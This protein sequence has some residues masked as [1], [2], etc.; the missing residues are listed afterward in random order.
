MIEK[1]DIFASNGWAMRQSCYDAEGKLL[2]YY[3]F[4]YNLKG[5]KD[6][7]TRCDANGSEIE[8][9]ELDYDEEGRELVS[10]GTQDDDGMIRMIKY[11]FEYDNNTTRTIH[12]DGISDVVDWYEENEISEDG[13]VMHSVRYSA[14]GIVQNSYDHE[15]DES[16]NMIKL[17]QYDAKGNLEIYYIFTYDNRGNNVLQQCY[18]ADGELLHYTENIYDEN[19]NVL[20][21][22]VYDGDGKLESVDSFE[23]GKE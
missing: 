8:H 6:S 4:T 12:H 23:T 9:L 7:V 21:W 18:R 22:R 10:Y 13:K 16:G 14:D 1:G 20:E 5:Q 3:Q 19:G 11:T 17:F 15:Y 2:Y